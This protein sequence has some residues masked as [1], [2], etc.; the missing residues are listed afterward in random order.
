MKFKV[1]FK[2]VTDE[3]PISIRQNFRLNGTNMYTIFDLPV[4]VTSD[5]PTNSSRPS[6]DSLDNEFL[7]QEALNTSANTFTRIPGSA[8]ETKN[9]S[10]NIGLGAGVAV[11]WKAAAH[12]L[13][14]SVFGLMLAF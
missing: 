2:W 14:I 12:W 11:D 13:W 5:I 10:G 9:S 6:C 8:L 3:A 4:Q 1:A 7:S